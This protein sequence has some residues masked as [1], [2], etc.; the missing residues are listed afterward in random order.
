MEIKTSRDR[1]RAKTAC[2]SGKDSYNG[3][4]K[5]EK[6][7]QLQHMIYRVA[8]FTGTSSP[9]VGISSG[10]GSPIVESVSL[11]R[12][13]RI[14]SGSGGGG[15]PVDQLS[16]EQLNMFKEQ[17]EGEVKQ[18]TISLNQLTLAQNKF[19]FSEDALKAIEPSNA[20]SESIISH[21]DKSGSQ[22]ASFAAPAVRSVK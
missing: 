13:L 19:G 8:A 5:T 15:V 7:G 11:V 12:E 21:V 17:L 14:M 22:L 4:T 18:L 16:L 6:T 9:F 1:V 3:E 20:G 10:A 2:E